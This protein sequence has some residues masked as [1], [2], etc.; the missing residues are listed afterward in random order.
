M[1]N[2][3]FHALLRPAVYCFALLVLSS[4]RYNSYTSRYASVAMP[5]IQPMRTMRCWVMVRRTTTRCHPPTAWRRDSVTHLASVVCVMR[6]RGGCP[7]IRLP[8]NALSCHRPA[9]NVTYRA[10]SLVVACSFHPPHQQL[11][12]SGTKY[13]WRVTED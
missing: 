2:G 6:P 5:Q 1:L 10:T 4:S 12:H 13:R 8:S 9:Q 3:S 11:M 7:H